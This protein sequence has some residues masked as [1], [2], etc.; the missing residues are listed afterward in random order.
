[1]AGAGLT[2]K[3]GIK[4]GHQMVVINAPAGYTKML[5]PLPEGVGLDTRPDGTFDF[6]QVFVYDKADVDN[7]AP[8][9]IAVLKPGGLLWFSYPKR[10]AKVETDI[11]RDVDWE[12]PKEAGMRPVSQVSIDDT[13]S[14]LRFRPVDDVKP[15]KS[16][17]GRPG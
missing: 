11:T 15:R 6:V 10:T 9:A 1:M 12:T 14:A 2:K 13:W 7:L 8:K 16:S 5:D 17:T 4:P 3:L